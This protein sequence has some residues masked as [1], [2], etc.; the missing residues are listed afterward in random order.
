VRGT[1]SYVPG[2]RAATNVELEVFGQYTACVDP[3]GT[4]EPDTA[5]AI[6]REQYWPH[7]GATLAWGITWR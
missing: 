5:Q 1:W 4:V 3:T 6:V 7:A 2:P